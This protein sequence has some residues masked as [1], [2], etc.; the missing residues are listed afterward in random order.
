M[1]EVTAYRYPYIFVRSRRTAETYRFI[2]N[3]DETLEHDAERFDQG[4]ARRAASSYLSQKRLSE[5][6]LSC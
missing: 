6:K 2:V 5:Q 3:A 1:F 4:D